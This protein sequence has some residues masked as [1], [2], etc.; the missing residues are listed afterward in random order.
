MHVRPEQQS[1][2]TAQTSSVLRQAGS[3]VPAVQVRSRQQSLRVA[4][5]SAAPAHGEAVQLPVSQRSPVQQSASRLQ[6]AASPAQVPGAHTPPVQS[7]EQ[8]SAETKQV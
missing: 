8:H 3:H 5:D 1:A 4:Q 7:D 6:A 2:S